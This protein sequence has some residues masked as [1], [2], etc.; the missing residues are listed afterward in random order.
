MWGAGG[1]GPDSVR[2]A[3]ASDGDDSFSPAIAFRVDEPL[4]D[5]VTD[6]TREITLAVVEFRREFG[7]RVAAV[8]CG[9][10]LKSNTPEHGVTY[11]ET[12]L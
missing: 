4:L 6:G 2:R 7:D 5:E 10:G 1:R 3:R 9:E 8:D 11:Y 12:G